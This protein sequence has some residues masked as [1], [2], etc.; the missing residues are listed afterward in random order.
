MVERRGYTLKVVDRW[1]PEDAGE[2]IAW[3]DGAEELKTNYE[4]IKPL[5]EGDVRSPEDR[6]RGFGY[7]M[8]SDDYVIP[9]VDLEWRKAPR[10]VRSS[11]AENFYIP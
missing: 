8:P 7:V 9:D 3:E 2:G 11:Q 4:R 1:T 6:V 5:P 10:G